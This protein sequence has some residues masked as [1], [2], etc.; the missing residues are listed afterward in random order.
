MLLTFLC[1]GKFYVEWIVIPFK[2]TAII[3]H[4]DIYAFSSLP[5]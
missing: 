5:Q 3:Y 4:K 1:F 2:I